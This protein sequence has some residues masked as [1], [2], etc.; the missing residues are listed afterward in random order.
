MGSFTNQ[1]LVCM[2]LLLFPAR[3]QVLCGLIVLLA[4]F[5]QHAWEACPR[6]IKLF[7]IT[8]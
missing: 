7:L 2:Q 6:T 5:H 3:W 4:M 1:L 8:A